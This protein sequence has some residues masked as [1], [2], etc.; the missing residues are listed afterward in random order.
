MVRDLSTTRASFARAWRSWGWGGGWGWG[1][2][3]NASTESRGT[4]G[5]RQWSLAGKGPLRIL[6]LCWASLGA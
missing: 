6:P 3:G 1:L 5:R 2:H 4:L